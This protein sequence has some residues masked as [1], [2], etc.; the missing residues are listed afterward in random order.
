MLFLKRVVRTLWKEHEAEKEIGASYE[1]IDSILYC[2]FDKKL[3]IEETE[4]IT[5]INRSTIEK[6]HTN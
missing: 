3:S 2:L 4:K 5:Q 6:I 1:E